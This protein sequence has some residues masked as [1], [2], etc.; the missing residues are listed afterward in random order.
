MDADATKRLLRRFALLAAFILVTFAGDRVI[1][2]WFGSLVD[3]SGLRFAEM[4]S[5]GLKK[6]VLILG[7]SRGQD[8][9]Y[10]PL[11]T[12]ELG[13]ECFSLT[14]GGFSTEI[15]EA[16]LLD[17]LDRNEKPE[18]VLLEITCLRGESRFGMGQM[19][20]FYGRSERLSKLASVYCPKEHAGTVVSHLYRYNQELFLRALYYIGRTDQTRIHRGRMLP[21]LI[22][23]LPN[24]PEQ[25]IEM[26][27]DYNL[28]ALARIIALT[29]QKGIRLELVVAPFAPGYR[30][31]IGNYR[32][33][34]AEVRKTVGPDVAIHDYS[35]QLTN[36]D[37]FIDRMHTNL[38]GAT[39]M[40]RRVVAD[41]VLRPAP[42]GT[43]AKSKDGGD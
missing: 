26:P 24:M 14:S 34:I 40:L 30:D 33:W 15:A 31:K 35:D 7:D 22:E 8:S 16:I 3:K 39:A 9:F 5:G 25:R 11:M 17:Y 4:Y 27:L 18:V 20:M 32:E 2:A 23:T 37:Y 43:P 38:D 36:L 10:T 13:K 41:G 29:Q 12:R 6:D 21:S 19:L 1:G 28:K 42:A